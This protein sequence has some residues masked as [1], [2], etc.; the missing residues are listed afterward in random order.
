MPASTNTYLKRE[1]SGVVSAGTIESATQPVENEP[2]HFA[3]KVTVE[4]GP[5]TYSSAVLFANVVWD[6]RFGVLTGI[7]GAARTRQSGGVR[8]VTLPNTGLI[9]SYPRFVL[10]PPA[11][12]SAPK[13][14]QPTTVK[15]P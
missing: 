7:G 11:G 6:Y 10:D 2:L 3:G 5:L 8:S 13:L 12:S 1:A 4:I 14:L 15:R 9:L